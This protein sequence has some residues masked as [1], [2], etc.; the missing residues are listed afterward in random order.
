MG[1]NDTRNSLLVMWRRDKSPSCY[2]QKA[3]PAANKCHW[4]ERQREHLGVYNH[5]KIEIH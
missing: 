3:A 5:N 1:E 4:N 2:V